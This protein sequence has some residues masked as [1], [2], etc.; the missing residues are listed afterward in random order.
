FGGITNTVN[1]RGFDLNVFFSFEY[2]SKKVSFD[3]ILMEGGGVKD[4]NRSI[5]A[6]NLRR[7]QKAGDITDVPRVTSVGN[8]YVIEQNSR[9]LEDASLHRLKNVTLGYRLPEHLTSSAKISS[10]R[11]YVSGSNLWLL[12]KYLGPDPESNHTS[13]QNGK[14]IDVGTPPQPQSVQIGVNLTL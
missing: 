10:L 6:Y 14:R 11:V 13:D 7:W 5:L 2:G 4:A 3:R 9:F 1:F 12:A 8:N